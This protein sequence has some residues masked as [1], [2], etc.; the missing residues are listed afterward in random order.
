MISWKSN[1]NSL[2]KVEHYEFH[3]ID[4]NTYPLFRKKAYQKRHN[5]FNDEAGLFFL[6]FLVF[7][8][9]VHVFQYASMNRN[10]HKY[11]W[12]TEHQHRYVLFF[13]LY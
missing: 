2:D 4:P 6:Y 11:L 13:K 12:M 8:W 7:T 5:H 10:N 9:K 3:I 1:S